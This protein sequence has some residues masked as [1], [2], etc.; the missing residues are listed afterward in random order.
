MSPECLFCKI[1]QR[2]IPARI[3]SES[4]DWISFHDIQPQAPIHFLIIPKLHIES[5]SGTRPEHAPLLG[6]MLTELARLAS[7]LGVAD[8][9]YRVVG[10]CNRDGGQTVPHLHFHLLAGRPLHWPPG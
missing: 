1:A 2:K 4:S 8:S 7:E 9:G 10:N 3:L 5:L 6:S